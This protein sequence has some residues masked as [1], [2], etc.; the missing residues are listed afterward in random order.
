[1]VSVK[2]RL[3]TKQG[4]LVAEECRTHATNDNVDGNTE[5]DEEA[6]LLQSVS[7]HGSKERG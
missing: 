7:Q 2:M 1:M 4:A 5:R 6:C 3:R